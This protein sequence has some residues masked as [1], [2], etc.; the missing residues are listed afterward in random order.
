MGRMI[1]KRRRTEKDDRED[2]H[3]GLGKGR[4]MWKTKHMKQVS[5]KNLLDHFKSGEFLTQE[6]DGKQP[7][8][9]LNLLE[10]HF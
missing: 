5:R 2:D 6:Y 4:K 3:W 8:S 10:D 9:T 7:R 1:K